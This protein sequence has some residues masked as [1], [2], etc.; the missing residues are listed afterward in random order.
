MD[1]SIDLLQKELQ[2]KI[3]RLDKERAAQTAAFNKEQEERRVIEAA[4]RSERVKAIKEAEERVIARRQE[5]EAAE[6]QRQKE[7][8][9][10]RIKA[11]LLDNERQELVRQQ[12][13]KLEWLEAEIAKADYVQEQHAKAM[14]FKPAPADELILSDEA[15]INAHITTGEAAVGT[16]GL[17]VG[18]TLSEHL[19]SILRRA[20]SDVN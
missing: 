18:P 16:D 10:A 19:R 12:R 8:T 4:E 7:A 9:E 14:A 15:V 20:N 3:A 11:E 5:I 1:S 2:E 6:T 13:E 17:E